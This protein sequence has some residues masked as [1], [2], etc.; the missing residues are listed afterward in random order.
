[1]QTKIV[2]KD[3][4][5]LLVEALNNDEVIAFPTETVFG[6]GIVYDS[7]KAM[8][9]LKWAKQRPETKPFTLMIADKSWIKDFAKTKASDWKII[10]AFMPG[11][12]TLIFERKDEVDARITNGYET[13]GIRYPDDAFVQTLIKKV[14]KPLL[15]P[16]ANLSGMPAATSTKEVLDQLDGRISYVVEGVCESQEAS[17]IVSVVDEKIKLIRQGKIQLSEIEEVML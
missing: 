13:I 5:D 2:T 7:I 16:S 6:L 8:E 17:T 15:V 4:I 3:Q 12:L 1:M 11:A 10:D 9:R 14:G